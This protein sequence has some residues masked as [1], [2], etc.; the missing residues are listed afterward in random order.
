M[1]NEWDLFADMKR[2][3]AAGALLVSVETNYPVADEEGQAL[4]DLGQTYT[5]A[6]DARN[7]LL[8]FV[9]TLKCSFSLERELGST[10]VTL[11]V[12]PGLPPHSWPPGSVN[13]L[14]LDMLPSE[15]Y[16]IEL[17]EPDEPDDSDHGEEWKRLL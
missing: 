3:L 8:I 15:Y 14:E 16:G 13:L 10:R 7:E 2:R 9:R 12:G 4:D 11:R 6:P 5:L 17:D 1:K